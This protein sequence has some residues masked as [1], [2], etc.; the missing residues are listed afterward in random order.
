VQHGVHDALIG[1]A[2]GLPLLFATLLLF[3][4]LR[5]GGG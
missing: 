4:G 5:P 2:V 1:Q 3:G